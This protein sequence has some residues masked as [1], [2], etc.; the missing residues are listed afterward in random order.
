MALLRPQ[1]VIGNPVQV[2]A[3]AAGLTDT[4]PAIGAWDTPT[5]IACAGFDWVTLYFTYTRGAAG[6]AMDDQIQVSP[7]SA[8]VAGVEDW[9]SQSAY[10]VGAVVAGADTTSGIQREVVTYGSTAAAAE[11]WSFG[12]IRL[13]GTVER[14]RV[15][16]RESGVTATPGDC[17]IVGIFYN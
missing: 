15:F 6:G 13:D 14:I 1:P 5:E 16:T 17:H 12:P 11:T 8:N 3:T 9:F 2:K 7:Y 4:L 10:A